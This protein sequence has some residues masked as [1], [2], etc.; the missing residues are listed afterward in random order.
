[1]DRDRNIPNLAKKILGKDIF[2]AMNIA[3]LPVTAVAEIESAANFF[4]P[5]TDRACLGSILFGN[6]LQRDSEREEFVSKKLQKQAE[7]PLTEFLIGVFVPAP[8]RIIGFFSGRGIALHPFYIADDNGGDLI[9][10]GPLSEVMA[11]F[12]KDIVL[13]M[14]GFGRD[15]ALGAFEF[16][17]AARS[18]LQAGKLAL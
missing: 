15:V 3:M 10:Y 1:M 11:D 8:F 9:G 12:V 5:E 4:S 14:L 16:A 13:L 2:G 7:G 18:L 6:R 17:I